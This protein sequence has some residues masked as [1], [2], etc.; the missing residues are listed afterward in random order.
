MTTILNV[1]RKRLI[2]GAK[3]LCGVNIELI[4][5]HRNRLIFFA[6]RAHTK[7]IFFC[8]HN[9]LVRLDGNALEDRSTWKTVEEDDADWLISKQHVQITY[10]SRDKQLPS[11]KEHM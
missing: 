2:F 1:L 5:F 11:P 7:S 6:T 3:S 10:L 9:I 4:N 8:L